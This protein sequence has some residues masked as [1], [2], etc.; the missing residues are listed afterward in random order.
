MVAPVRPCRIEADDPPATVIEALRRHVA[1]YRAR[2]GFDPEVERVLGRVLACR[3]GALGT[4]QCVCEACGWTGVAANSCRDRHCPQCQGR[5]TAEWLDARQ[6]RMLDLPHFQVVFTLPAELRPLARR[7][8]RVLYAPLFRAGTSVLQDLAAQRFKA[9]MGIT[10]TLHTWTTEMTYHPHIHCIVTAGGLALDGSQWVHSRAAF[11]FPQRVLGMMFR[12]RFLQGL[13]LALGAGEL[14]LP[15]PGPAAEKLFRTQLRALSR[16]LAR[17]VVHVDPPK[18]R[19]VVH[20][21]GYLARYVKRIAISD[22]R[23]LALS[24]THVT[25][26]TRNGPLTLEGTEFVRRFALHILPAGFRKVR[27]YGLYAPGRC[28]ERLER[29]RAVLDQRPPRPPPEGELADAD[30]GEE[31]ETSQREPCPA[32]GEKRMVR[33]FA[34]ARAPVCP[35]ARGSP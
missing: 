29:A 7:N 25:I 23:I 14:R 13:I 33:L 22:A 30:R 24:D 12:G 1:A 18:G 8:P 31:A 27:H 5:A 4:H 3:T 2:V 11:L 34:D 19:P 6:E 15:E 17:W 16:R 26:A 20:I 21:A 28:N 35:M 10:A 32:C 9:T